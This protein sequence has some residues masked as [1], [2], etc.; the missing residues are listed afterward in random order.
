MANVGHLGARWHLFV[1]RGLVAL[2]LPFALIACAGGQ[3]PTTSPASPTTL[4]STAAP[5]HTASATPPTSTPF[6]ASPYEGI[7][8]S[9]AFTQE[10]MAQMIEETGLDPAKLDDIY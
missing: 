3:A 6:A 7:W 2:I 10:T 8:A 5:T 9:E 1:M 4:S